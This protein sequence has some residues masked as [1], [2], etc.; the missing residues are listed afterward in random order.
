MSLAIL[1]KTILIKN[2][3]DIDIGHGSCENVQA[4]YICIVQLEL[5]ESTHNKRST[6]LWCCC[7]RLRNN[8][9]LNDAS[10]VLWNVW[11]LSIFHVWVLECLGSIYIPM[12][13][14]FMF[15]LTSLVAA[16]K[17]ICWRW[18][19]GVRKNVFNRF[20]GFVNNQRNV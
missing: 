11:V 4:S 20:C 13:N 12:S 3:G 2:C 19:A 15:K 5:Q 8:D 16:F 6:S 7:K 14:T 10:S 1:T 18:N 17:T 9:R